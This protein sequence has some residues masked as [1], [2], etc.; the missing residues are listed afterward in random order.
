MRWSLFY[1]IAVGRGKVLQPISPE[2]G[3]EL[4]NWIYDHP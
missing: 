4:M 2:R 3:E 1:L